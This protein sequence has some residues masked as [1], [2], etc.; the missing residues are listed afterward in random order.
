MRLVTEKAY[1]AVAPSTGSVGVLLLAKPAF[2]SDASNEMS[3]DDMLKRKSFS[4][5]T[6]RSQRANWCA[7][8]DAVTAAPY[9]TPGSVHRPVSACACSNSCVG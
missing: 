3:P 4:T 6:L 1:P 2:L 9:T 8:Y 5:C 7:M